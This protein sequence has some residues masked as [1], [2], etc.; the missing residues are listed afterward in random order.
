M[1]DNS[2]IKIYFLHNNDELTKLI[3]EGTYPFLGLYTA[4]LTEKHQKYVLRYLRQSS[5]PIDSCIAAL[6]RW[7]ALLSIYLTSAVLHGYGEDGQA[8][9]WRHLEAAITPNRQLSVE[10][11]EQL[12]ENYRK[13]CLALGLPVLSRL[14]GS[15]YMINAF[16]GSGL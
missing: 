8:A 1:P 9:V 11:R 6:R 13:A 16:I 4:K 5:A 15:N 14:S 10:K 12:W 3:R 2:A 7:P